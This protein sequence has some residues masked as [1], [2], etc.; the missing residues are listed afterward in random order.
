V[1][2]TALIKK[3]D[4]YTKKLFGHRILLSTFA[5]TIGFWKLEIMKNKLRYN[6]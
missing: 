4:W 5:E 6:G 2:V 3:I 1:V